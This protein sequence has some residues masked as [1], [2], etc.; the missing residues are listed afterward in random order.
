[1]NVRSTVVT[2]A[3]LGVLLATAPA[4][5]AAVRVDVSAQDRAYLNQAHQ[6]NLFEIVAGNLVDRGGCARVR[7]LGPRFAAHHTALDAELIGVATRTDTTLYSVPD[8]GQ[9]TRIADL[10][11]RSGDDFDTAWLRDQLAAHLRGLAEGEVETRSGWSPEVKDL[12]ARTAPVLRH[13][14]EEVVAA[15]AECTPG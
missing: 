3:A 13:H 10:S 4:A 9:L 15:M 6:N 11:T 14:L 12:A 1:M 5:A 7:E 8:P 2:A